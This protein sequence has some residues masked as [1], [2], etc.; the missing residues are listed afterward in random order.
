[1]RNPLNLR[2]SS[3]LL[4][5]FSDL[6]TP[7]GWDF[8]PSCDLQETEKEFIVKADLPGMKKEDIKI[9]VDGHRLTVSGERR[10]EKEEQDAKRHHTET[11]YGSFMRMFTLPQ[12]IDE[13]NV[14]AQFKD[15]V[16]KIT[17]PK[18]EPTNKKT[19]TIQ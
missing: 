12:A 8:S 16:L 4:K 3:N 17:V 7:E 10:E 9:E 15:G 2:R 5:N 6:L 11:Y 14:Q 18:T 19:I 1:M 13:A